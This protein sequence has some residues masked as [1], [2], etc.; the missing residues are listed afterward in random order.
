MKKLIFI[1]LHVMSLVFCIKALANPIPAEKLFDSPFAANLAFSPKG[2]YI[3]TVLSDEKGRF[4]ALIDNT[5]KVMQ[6]I[7]KTGK[8]EFINTVTWLNDEYIL[9]ETNN[10]GNR[11][12]II[13]H[14]FDDQG[15]LGW[16]LTQIRHPGYLLSVL[17]NDPDNI[18]YAQQTDPD[19]FGYEVFKLPPQQ[20]LNRSFDSDYKIDG[21]PEEGAYFSYDENFDKLVKAQYDDE[22]KTVDVSVKSL[23][24]PLWSHIYTYQDTDYIFRPVGFLSEQTMAVITNK[25]S[26]KLALYSFDI[27]NQEI[28]TLLFEHEKYDL[29]SASISSTSNNLES[30][31]YFDHGRFTRIYFADD[32]QKESGLIEQAFPDTQFAI[33]AQNPETGLKILK[34]FS[35]TDPGGFYLYD[36]KS[37]TAELLFKQ[38]PKLEGYALLPNQALT[39]QSE[40]GKQ[41]EAYLTLPKGVDHNT[42]LVMPHGGPINVRENDSFN[43]TTQYLASRGFSILRVNFRGSRGFGKAFTNEGRGQF[44][45]LIE[46]DISAVVDHVL[47]TQQFEHVCSMGASYG[48]Y[49]AFMLAIKHPE[50]YDCIIGTFGVY[51]LPL[52]FNDNNFS[53]L[54]ENRKPIEKVVGKLD[55]SLFDVSPVY[56][57]D[58]VKAAALLIAGERDSIASAEHTHR[59]EYVL[60]KLNKPVDAVYYK[61]AGHGHD[62]WWGE[63]H[64]HTLVSQFLFETLNLPPMDLSGLSIDDKKLIH[65]E[66]VRLGASFN[67]D[68]DLESDN[69]K[70]MKYYTIASDYGGAEGKFALG[71]FFENGELVDKLPDEALSWYEE[72]SEGGS[73]RA[74]F[75][76]GEWYYDGKNVD[77]DLKKSFE[78]FQLSQQQG[79]DAAANIALARAYCLGAGISKDIEQCIKLLALKK[80]EDIKKPKNKVS[81]LS[82]HYRNKLL[83]EIMISQNL[84]DVE[85][86]KLIKFIESELDVN[87]IPVEVVERDFGLLEINSN[88]NYKYD[89]STTITYKT[90]DRFGVKFNIGTSRFH[91]EWNR[92]RPIIIRNIVYN[93]DNSSQVLSS[94]LFWGKQDDWSMTVIFDD[95]TIN[96]KSVE[97]QVYDLLGEL[98][99][100]R[101]FE[102]VKP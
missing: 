36:Q 24:E 66:Y 31:S 29:V 91:S 44:G 67:S 82:K 49:S 92:I 6:P 64:E 20:L 7:Y 42:L 1:A 23:N 97:I 61:K 27:V 69:Q 21:L 80:F 51:D 17:P 100:T 28:E 85:R 5:S 84:T 43:A 74:S 9:F 63:W 18:M 62:N 30:V 52:I 65:Q 25:D 81:D 48:G 102:I 90:D 59:M 16:R 86:Q 57:A 10:N 54:E 3:S 89:E 68:E 71:T 4:L 73:G 37:K 99:F 95:R 75:T 56:L 96:A 87:F 33:I 35:A 77:V 14:V 78:L 26:D 19:E 41:I 40:D 76:L 101:T 70:S 45:Q 72:A 13:A 8:R 47:A 34:T 98:K 83:S 53:V 11:R 38:F 22:T 12:D 93:D 88:G 2:K 60:R 46:E 94:S 55:D 39:I 15:K 79:F 58:R 50:L 32:R